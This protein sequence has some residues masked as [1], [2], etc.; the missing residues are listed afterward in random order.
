MAYRDLDVLDAAERAADLVE[1]LIE[2]APRQ[3]IGAGQMRRAVQA[4][5]NNIGEGIGRG[6]AGD[7]ARSMVVARGEAE[8]TIRQLNA[9]HRRRRITTKDYWRIHNL[10]TTIVKML[11]S[12][13]RR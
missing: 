7:K 4:I 1:E 11:D 2:R 13:L 8:E 10:L 12:L 3:L 9:N 5:S 6:G